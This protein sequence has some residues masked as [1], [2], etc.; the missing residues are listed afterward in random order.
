MKV[1]WSKESSDWEF[2]AETPC[3]F[4]IGGLCCMPIVKD[5]DF[6]AAACATAAKKIQGREIPVLLVPRYVPK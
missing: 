2:K 6:L 4:L 3:V 1:G 5:A